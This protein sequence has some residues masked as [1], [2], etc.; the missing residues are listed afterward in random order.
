M[1]PINVIDLIMAAEYVDF[2]NFV[3]TDEVLSKHIECVCNILW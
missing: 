1:E 3:L 2:V